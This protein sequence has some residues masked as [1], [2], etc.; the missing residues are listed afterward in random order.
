DVWAEGWV[1]DVNIGDS[2]RFLERTRV[3]ALAAALALLAGCDPVARME[4]LHHR[5]GPPPVPPEVLAYADTATEWVG[6]PRHA[7]GERGSIGI[8]I[9]WNGFDPSCVA[10]MP[11]IEAWH[12]A[13]ARYGVRITGLHF[14]PYAFAAD[15]AVVGANTR[16]LGL[17]FASAV[18]SAPPPAGLNAGRGPVVIWPGGGDPAP[19]WLTTPSDANAF[20]AR[21]RQKLRQTRPDAGFPA[22]AALGVAREAVPPMPVRTLRLGTHGIERGPIRG[23][24]V[25]RAQPF[26]S[27]FRA[28]QEGP[29]DTPVP[30]GWWTP[31]ADAI[32]AARG[33]AANVLA[34]RY[35]AGPLG[36]VMAP[37]TATVAKVWVLQ[38]EKWLDAADAGE[39]VRYDSRGASYVDVGETR[40][41][42]VTRGGAHVLK[43]SPDVA[44]VLFHAITIEAAPARP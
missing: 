11:A 18:L 43:L 5:D 32:E 14:A 2:H 33:G 20:E 6:G 21:I 27:P 39:D 34:I 40:L 25:D 4:Q 36:L 17:R 16:R 22:D 42:A 12:E 44:G 31:R 26:V 8:M 24:A 38:D 3:L 1:M 30:V 13:Y 28:E 23:A 15:S 7:R 9:L 37:P 41:Y 19:H 10:M 29:L 35:D